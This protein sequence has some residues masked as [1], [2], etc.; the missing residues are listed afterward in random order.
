[1]SEFSSDF[2]HRLFAGRA[3]GQLRRAQ[4]PA[5]PVGETRGLVERR[6]GDSPQPQPLPVEAAR[7][8]AYR[9]CLVDGWNRRKWSV[10]IG[11]F[12]IQKR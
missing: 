6:L 12:T 7:L 9:W 11:S 10:E 1:M 5:R 2:A 3:M 4:G 8:I